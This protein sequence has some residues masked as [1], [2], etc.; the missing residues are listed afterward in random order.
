MLFLAKNFQVCLDG[1]SHF[2]S[3]QHRLEHKHVKFW[4][5]HMFVFAHETRLLKTFA[6]TCYVCSINDDIK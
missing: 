2:S 4:E 1:P 6:P 3:N 5:L